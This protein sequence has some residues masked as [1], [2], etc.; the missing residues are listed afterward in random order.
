[1]ENSV[2]LLLSKIS[3]Q[4]QVLIDR[5][6]VVYNIDMGSLKAIL[7]APANSF[8]PDFHE[9]L[10]NDFK[11]ILQPRKVIDPANSGNYKKQKKEISLTSIAEA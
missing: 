9:K 5:P 1:M 2:E 10:G 3:D 7:E 11:Q 4:L 8:H 6:N